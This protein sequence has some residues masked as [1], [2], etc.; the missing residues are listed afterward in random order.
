MRQ[1]PKPKGKGVRV[2]FEE[3]VSDA[4]ESVSRPVTDW[5][6]AKGAPVATNKE[7]QVWR[8]VRDGEN[9]GRIE[10]S[11]RRVAVLTNKEE[12]VS[13]ACESVSRPVTDWSE[14]KGGEYGRKY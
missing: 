13:D 6:E 8:R 14:A 9:P 7:R 2:I 4:C 3:R 10:R 1:S 11:E 5:S 12:R